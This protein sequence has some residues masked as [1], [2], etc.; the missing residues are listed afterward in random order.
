MG[1]QAGN[2]AGNPALQQLVRPVALA[3]Q[4]VLPVHDAL[5]PLLP[6]GG[7]RR[8]SVVRVGG[9]SAS[10]ALSLTF[11]L[12][13][14][15]TAEGSWAAIVGVDDVGAVAA[16]E[17]GV[18]LERLAL[19]PRA[20]IEQWTVVTAALL[21]ALD[22]VVV[23]PPARVRASDARRLA[24]RARERGS[25][26]VA[27]GDRWNETVDLRLAIGAVQ[28]LGL[29][30]G[31]GYLRARRFEVMANGRGAASRERRAA[32]WM[33]APDGSPIATAADAGSGTARLRARRV[34]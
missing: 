13:S 12:I 17:A 21:D 32:L 15:A 31:N 9:R 18:A 7:L 20:P 33:P 10:A 23:R 6:W 1:G 28:W 25:V 22:L 4:H 2:Q 16:E 8:G 3:Q 34:S 26:L 14:R 30:E 19:V 27:V 5:D 11:G 24:T 29:G